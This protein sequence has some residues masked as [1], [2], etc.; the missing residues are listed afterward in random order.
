MTRDKLN[1]YRQQWTTDTDI[2][3]NLRFST[4]SRL[5]G[6]AANDRFQSVSVRYLPGTPKVLEVFRERLIE[7][8]GILGLCVLRFSLG[9]LEFV[10]FN[11]LKASVTSIGVELKPYELNQ[12]GINCLIPLGLRLLSYVTAVKIFNW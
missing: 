3:R 4:E 8:Y 12:V 7:K 10:N 5:A 2:G 11:S 6:N 1:D 9:N